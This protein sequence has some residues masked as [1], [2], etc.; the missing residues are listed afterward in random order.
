MFLSVSARPLAAAMP[1]LLVSAASLSSID[2]LAQTSGEMYMTRFAGT[3]NIG[4][5]DYYYDGVTFTLSEIDW[6]ATT[7]GAD[8]I[9]ANP[10]Q[11]GHLLVGAQQY[12]AI[13]DVDS[14]YG[15]TMTYAAPT[16]IYHLVVVDEKTVL[17]NS[18]PGTIARFTVS[19]SGTLD[20]GKLIALTGDDAWVTQVIPTPAGYFYTSDSAGSGHGAFGRLQFSADGLSATTARIMTKLPAAHGAVYDPFSETILSFGDEHITQIDLNG[21]IVGDLVVP[22][23]EWYPMHFDQGAVDGQGHVFAASNTGHLAF[24]DYSQS[25]KID[26][27]SNFVAVKFIAYYL[28]DVAPLIGFGGTAAVQAESG[29]CNN[30]FGNGADCEP[31]GHVNNAFARRQMQDELG[32]GGAAVRTTKKK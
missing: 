11:P 13:H 5:F 4:K 15:T 22:S 9:V 23:P 8:G 32:S 10:R 14:V 26:Q 7:L 29:K 31:A 27:A 18:I 20:A 28:D 1:L 25:R 21:N 12:K 6:F 24:V 16:D 19:P 2:A 30:G 3:P 17:G